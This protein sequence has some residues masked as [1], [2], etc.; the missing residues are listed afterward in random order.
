MAKLIA[1]FILDF[2]KQW[3]WTIP[4]GY[5]LLKAIR[6][7]LRQKKNPSSLDALAISA[8]EKLGTDDVEKIALQKAEQI[9]IRVKRSKKK[10]AKPRKMS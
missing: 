6:D 7:R 3:G 9:I 2:L 1:T 5:K 8:L 4:S 10:K